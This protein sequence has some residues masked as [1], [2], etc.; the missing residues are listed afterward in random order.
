[1]V[2]SLVTHKTCPVLIIPHSFM[3]QYTS[4]SLQGKSASRTPFYLTIN[5]WTRSVFAL[6]AHLVFESDLV[7]LNEPVS[8]NTVPLQFSL[9]S[10]LSPQSKFPPHLIM[11]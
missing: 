7:T 4:K 5:I 8:V 6:C 3:K 1:M 10:Q 11:I 9:L 2:F